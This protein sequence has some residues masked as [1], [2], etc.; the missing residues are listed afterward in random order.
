[1]SYL[2]FVHTWPIRN[3]SRCARSFKPGDSLESPKFVTEANGQRYLWKIELYPNGLNKQYKGWM[4]AFVVL[5][6]GPH[7]SIFG[8]YSS[9]IVDHKFSLVN[10]RQSKESEFSVDKGV[11]E[12]KLLPMQYRDMQAAGFIKGDTLTLHYKL[13]LPVDIFQLSTFTF[14]P[15]V[16]SSDRALMFAGIESP[17]TTAF[18]TVVVAN[19]NGKF[20]VDRSV[21]A[22][23]SKELARLLGD[24]VERVGYGDDQIA[25]WLVN[26]D[27]RT[28]TT[29]EILRFVY[30]EQAQLQRRN[31]DI[32][33]IMRAAKDFDLKGASVILFVQIKLITE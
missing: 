6:A 2:Q 17:K 3:I 30:Y 8:N 9:A 26:I 19:D 24:E 13:N 11:G 14:I 15:S 1:M 7:R 27:A 4:S 28:A 5:L 10:H 33:D 18:D 32:Y 23:A 20:F 16:P 12:A 22:S 21:L 31:V 29:R 25:V